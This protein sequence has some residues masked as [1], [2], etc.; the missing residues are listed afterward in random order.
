MPGKGPLG[1]CQWPPQNVPGAPLGA[2]RTS[3][4]ACDARFSWI[5]EQLWG[6][7][8]GG[9]GRAARLSVTGRLPFGVSVSLS[10]SL[11]RSLLGPPLASLPLPV[12]SPPPT[13]AGLWAARRWQLNGLL[14]PDHARPSGS[15]GDK[16]WQPA[17]LKGQHP[18]GGEGEP[19]CVPK[20]RP[21]PRW[22][23][24]RGEGAIPRHPSPTWS[25]GR[26]GLGRPPGGGESALMSHVGLGFD[27]GCTPPFL[28][29]SVSP[30]VF[31]APRAHP[32]GFGGRW[33]SLWAEPR[34]PPAYSGPLASRRPHAVRTG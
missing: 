30:S 27:L 10:L 32:Q 21:S 14:V 9:G 7:Q 34:C 4:L 33:C 19:A 28:R 2:Q 6:L 22:C 16:P 31:G 25:G 18:E 29:A 13:Q 1:V 8:P 26:P 23:M 15:P 3:V 17:A 12:C 11:S 24:V 20:P 5:E